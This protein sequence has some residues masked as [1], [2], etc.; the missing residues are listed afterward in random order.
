MRV[1]TILIAD[2]SQLIRENLSKLIESSPVHARILTAPEVH[3]A[4]IA[5]QRDEVDVLILDIQMPGGTGFEVLAYMKSMES[6]PYTIVLTNYAGPRLRD[7][8]MELGADRFFDKSNEYEEL[9]D[10]LEELDGD[11]SPELTGGEG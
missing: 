9:I 10:V 11:M 5:L 1:V 6:R 3:S 7:R 4:I 8:S 2:D